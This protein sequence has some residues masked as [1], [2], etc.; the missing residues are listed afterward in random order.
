[1]AELAERGVQT[2]P[3]MNTRTIL[4]WTLLSAIALITLWLGPIERGGAAHAGW[5]ALLPTLAVLTLALVMRR[6][7]EALVGGCLFG[8]LMLAGPDFLL[9]FAD[10]GLA[11]MSNPTIGW[12]ILVCGFLGSLIALLGLSGATQAFSTWL[13][14]RVHGRRSTLFSA[15]LLG[16]LIFIDDYLNALAVSAS[17]RKLCDRYKIS[18]PM[19]AYVV[20]STAAPMCVLVPLSTWAIYSAGLLEG[21]G[22]AAA[23]E[24]LAVYLAAVP[25]MFYA[26]IALLMVPLVALGVI[27][28]MGPMRTAERLTAEGRAQIEDSDLDEPSA[29]ATPRLVNFLLPLAALIGFTLYLD[30]DAF[31]G[32]VCALL[33]T[34]V[35]YAAQ[36]LAS[37]EEL[38]NAVQKGFQSMLMP[39]G[40]V[41][42]SFVLQDINEQLGLTQYVI[43]SLQ[44]L[45]AGHWLPAVI[46]I[47]LS[48]VTFSTGSFWGTFAVAFPIVI[49]LAAALD[50]NLSLTIGAVVSAGAFGSHACFYGDATVLSAKG[51]GC[52]PLQHA[53]TQLPYVL[54]AAALATLMFIVMG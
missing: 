54:I 28:V 22:V 2:L 35:L 8:Y 48:L 30:V 14:T 19:L 6:T 1:M 49:P 11:V 16:L 34:L 45:M 33:L 32:V 44:P 47:T 12:I 3:S 13:G 41:V 17:M 15:W 18:R 51:S 20:D 29:Q 4:G 37:L 21:N 42:A 53:V 46:F 50:A 43:D 27:P 26:W 23:G 38:F 52:T 7:L 40:I 39:L 5:L 9:R 31:K 10:T 24:G 25:Y 36:R